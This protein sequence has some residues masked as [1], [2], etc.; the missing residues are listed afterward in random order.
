MLFCTFNMWL[1]RFHLNICR[2]PVHSITAAICHWML[3][4][5]NLP[6]GNIDPLGPASVLGGFTES[7][8]FFPGRSAPPGLPGT[9]LASSAL[10]V[11]CPGKASV[12]GKVR[13]L[14]QVLSPD[15][16]FLRL[17]NNFFFFFSSLS[18]C[19]L[20]LHSQHIEVPG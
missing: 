5:R 8:K 2:G 11:P 6:S 7:V 1:P 18:F 13:R 9:F 4:W 15:L 10:K 19:F 20:E 14:G 16:F 12:P 3:Q 17:N